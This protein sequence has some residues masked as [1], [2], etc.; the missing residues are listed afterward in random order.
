MRN[1]AAARVVVSAMTDEAP[2]SLDGPPV[3][4]PPPRRP[5]PKSPPPRPRPSSY[6]SAR[7]PVQR[8]SSYS[9]PE[10]RF[11]RERPRPSRPGPYRAPGPR[12]ERG[13]RSERGER[14]ERGERYER[15]DRGPP[16]PPFVADPDSTYYTRCGMCT[17]SYELDPTKFGRGKKVECA[18]CSN[19][20][21]QKV[22]RLMVL[23][24]V[25]GFKDYPVEDKD[26]IIEQQNKARKERYRA[27][28]IERESGLPRGGG[29]YESGDR[30]DS[31]RRGRNYSQF[32]VFI[33]NLPFSCTEEQL[34]ELFRDKLSV[35]RISIV[36]DPTGR[37][38]GFAFAD[39][40]SDSEV[41]FA[42]NTFDGVDI[43]GRAISVKVGK[44]Y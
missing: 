17:A 7:P 43:D 35:N 4:V 14:F 10:R 13:E 3:P 1:R 12:G 26:D 9:P 37:S 28:N 34:A 21:F 42:V 29:R 11:D 44:K 5:D 20:W 33:G 24:D 16:R 6:A 22:D 15:S 19:Q 8:P 40:N 31:A 27:R 41:Q 2:P 36:K 38:K 18:V 32:S 23:K 30:R 39:L 25:E